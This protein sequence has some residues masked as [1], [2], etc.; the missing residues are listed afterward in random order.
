[1]GL[2]SPSRAEIEQQFAD[3]LSHPMPPLD[4]VYSVEFGECDGE[5]WGG[6]TH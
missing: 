3:L 4:R 5:S 1:V 6:A 2:L